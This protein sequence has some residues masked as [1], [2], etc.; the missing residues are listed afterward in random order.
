[1]GCGASAAATAGP[2]AGAGLGVGAATAGAGAVGDGFV[3]DPRSSFKVP[4]PNP[5]GFLL[6]VAT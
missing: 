1:L 6:R 5:T 3:N 4:T 2:G